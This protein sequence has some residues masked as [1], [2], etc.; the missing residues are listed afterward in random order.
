MGAAPAS[1]GWQDE[2]TTELKVGEGSEHPHP[3]GESGVAAPGT[4]AGV[5][6]GGGAL[7][8]AAL[9]RGGEAAP[10]LPIPTTQPR[11]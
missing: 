7:R 6:R 5:S 1:G 4:A 3:L 11:R 9:A 8:Y 2:K 10:V